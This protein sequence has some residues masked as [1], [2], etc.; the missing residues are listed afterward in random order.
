MEL[1]GVTQ[2]FF[3]PLFVWNNPFGV[4]DLL[5]GKPGGW[6]V[7]PETENCCRVKF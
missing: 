2:Y 5:K 7:Q 1:F 6:F 3:N 4:D